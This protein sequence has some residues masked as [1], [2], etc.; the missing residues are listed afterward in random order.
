MDLVAIGHFERAVKTDP[1]PE[2]VEQAWYQLGS[3]YRRLKRMDDARNADDH[4]PNASKMKSK[5]KSSRNPSTNTRRARIRN[6]LQSFSNSN[7]V[8][9]TPI[10]CQTR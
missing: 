2:V 4:V 10:R 1:D 5:Q 6:S 7:R 9:Q 8:Y 3:G